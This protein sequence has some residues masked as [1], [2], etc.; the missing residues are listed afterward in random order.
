MNW[1]IE[2]RTVG[3][4]VWND[5]GTPLGVFQVKAA[6]VRQVEA[7]WALNDFIPFNLDKPY[8]YPLGSLLLINKREGRTRGEMT[9][10][11]YYSS[12]GIVR[13]AIPNQV[14]LDFGIR[15]PDVDVDVLSFKLPTP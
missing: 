10:E 12:N 1:T 7:L 6:A 15:W 9:A 13:L 3:W 4:T 11:V 8:C 14:N 5:K 2:K